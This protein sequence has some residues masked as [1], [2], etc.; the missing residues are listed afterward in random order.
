M[1]SYENEY[2]NFPQ[3]K[4]TLH[5]FKNVDGTIAPLINE[6]NLLRSSGA[7]NQAAQIIQNNSALL[8][9]YIFDA[10]TMNTIIEEIYNTQIY[11]KKQQQ[12][13]YFEDEEPL[14]EPDDVWI[15]G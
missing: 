9:Q 4:I 14:A 5:R 10:T 2:S 13:I 1:T 3:E 8:S 6:I 12:F 11:A 15:G 7:Y